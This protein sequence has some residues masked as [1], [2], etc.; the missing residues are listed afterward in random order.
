[1]KLTKCF[2]EQIHD[3]MM[4][5]KQQLAHY[6]EINKEYGRVEKRKVYIEQDLELVDATHSWEKLNTIVLVESTRVTPQKE[7]TENRFYICSLEN[8]KPK[9][10]L[11]LSRQYCGAARAV[12]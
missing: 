6:K 1:M 7:S 10:Y 8:K 2:E 5:R 4:S 9:K 3:W 11:D 12:S